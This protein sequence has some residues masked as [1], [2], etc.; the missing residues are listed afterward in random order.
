MHQLLKLPC[1]HKKDTPLPPLG[2][3]RLIFLQR[4]FRGI[5]LIVIDEKSMMGQQRLV[6]ID[7]RLKQIR[8]HRED[9][10]FGGVSIIIL[11]DW[12]RIL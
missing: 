11:G 4:R 8:P 1:S 7:Q 12:Y 5:G 10:A 9:T 2:S 6:M 3:D